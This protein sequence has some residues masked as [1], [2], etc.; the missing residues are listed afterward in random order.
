MNKLQKLNRKLANVILEFGKERDLIVS[1]KT[2]L[3]RRAF[4]CCIVCKKG[5]QLRRWSL[6]QYSGTNSTHAVQC[7]RPQCGEW[8]QIYQNPHREKI[9]NLVD[10]QGVEKNLIFSKIFF[11]AG[12]LMPMRQTF[13]TQE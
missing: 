2:S 4:I 10:H 6:L 3:V 7:P 8:N 13:P 11:W 12:G 1:Q 9:L 5:S